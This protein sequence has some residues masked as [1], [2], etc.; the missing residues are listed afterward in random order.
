MPTQELRDKIERSAI[1]RGGV[2]HEFSQSWAAIKGHRQ[3]GKFVNDKAVELNDSLYVGGMCHPMSMYWLALRQRGQKSF[4]DWL[5]PDGVWDSGAIN[6]LVIKTVMYKNGRNHM[7]PD[8]VH[9]DFDDQFFAHYN[10]KRYGAK[11]RGLDNMLTYLDRQTVGYHMM[12]LSRDGGGHAVAAHVAPGGESG[13]FDPNF[14]DYVFPT[15]QKLGSFV[16]RFMQT[17][18]YADKYV[19][20]QSVDTFR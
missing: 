9:T 17:S 15:P 18:G 14:G 3:V 11:L 20:A 8:E 13:F 4:F 10:L 2:H 19:R 1:R 16:R 5:R 6:V 7:V 12:S